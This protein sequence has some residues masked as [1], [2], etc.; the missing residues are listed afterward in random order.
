MIQIPK[1]DNWETPEGNLSAV[2]RETR[3]IEKMVGGVAETVLRPVFEVTSLPN[4]RY[5][6]LV[7]KNYRVSEPEKFKADFENWLGDDFYDLLDTEGN[8]SREALD[9]LIGKAADLQVVHITND[10]YKAA[11]CHLAVIAP[12][13]TLTAATAQTAMK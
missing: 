11:F 8:L 6:Y 1:K 3:V 13:G 7:S 2:Y 9:T 5:R 12:P 10:A 4:P